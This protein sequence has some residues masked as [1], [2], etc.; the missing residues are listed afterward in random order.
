MTTDIDCRK[1]FVKV[2]SVD[3][4]GSELGWY[5]FEREREAKVNRE[6]KDKSFKYFWYKRKQRNES[7]AASRIYS[8]EL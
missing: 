2:V 4:W 8:K 3:E 6:S 7:V 5:M 1:C